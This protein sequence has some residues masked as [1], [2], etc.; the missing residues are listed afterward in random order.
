MKGNGEKE[1][2]A[3]PTKDSVRDPAEDTLVKE[4]TIA[5][6]EKSGD[7][8][9][10]SG[11]DIFNPEAE[12]ENIDP[13]SFSKVKTNYGS[14]TKGD[15]VTGIEEPHMEEYNNQGTPDYEG[16]KADIEADTLETGK[17]VKGHKTHSGL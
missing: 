3:L 4:G 5:P 7:P 17:K 12:A 1:T 15:P 10:V 13:K 11:E 16:E 14:E 2:K 9:T 6:I 8:S